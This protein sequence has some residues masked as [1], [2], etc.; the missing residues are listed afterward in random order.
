MYKEYDPILWHGA[1]SW[2]KRVFSSLH[3]AICRLHDLNR[4]RVWKIPSLHIF[5]DHS[6][7]MNSCVYFRIAECL[8]CEIWWL[9][10]GMC[11]QL[12]IAW[13]KHLAYPQPYF[14]PLVLNTYEDIG[15]QDRAKV[16]LASTSG[17]EHCMTLR[18]QDNMLL[19]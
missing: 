17:S 11:A 5:V 2:V 4:E 13:G 14:H 10:S 3:L 15:E 19:C 6:R 7:S 12:A 8:R 18:V 16:R 1:K 9:T